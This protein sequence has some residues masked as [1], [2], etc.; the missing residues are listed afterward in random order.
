MGRRRKNPKST[1]TSEPPRKGLMAQWREMALEKKLSIVFIPVFLTAVG[2]LVPN[3][4]LS[5]DGKRKEALETVGPLVVRNASTKAYDYGQGAAV[6]VRLRNTGESSSFVHTAELRVKRF[7][8]AEVCVPPQG[9]VALSASYNVVLPA[10]RAQ[11]AAQ[12]VTLEQE[13]EA[14]SVDR[15]AFAV[16]AEQGSRRAQE[17]G[18]SDTPSFYLLDVYLYHDTSSNPLHA[19]EA[20]VALPFPR[21]EQFVPLDW[22]RFGIPVFDPECLSR[23]TARLKSVLSWAAPYSAEL[24]AFAAKIVNTPTELSKIPES[25]EADRA[26]A[27]TRARATVD[28][29]RAGDLGRAC[30]GLDRALDGYL[31]VARKERCPNYMKRVT[32]GLALGSLGVPQVIETHRGWY[33]FA[34]AEPSNGSKHRLVVIAQR[35]AVE[36]GSPDPKFTWKVTNVYDEAD[37]PLLQLW[38]A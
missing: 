11:G 8:P 20:L 16:R 22:A 2:I 15:F 25:T 18:A 17:A 31:F 21:Q 27:S 4:L 19:G 6:E 1:P 3:V 36:P 24:G 29:L 33:K 7:T 13:V 5:G 9:E 30:A 14:G 34:T 26:K 28:A 37:G 10:E 35:V 23:N 12:K 38:G 32:D